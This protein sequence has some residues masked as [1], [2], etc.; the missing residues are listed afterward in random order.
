MELRHLRYFVALAE[1]LSFTRA[2]E[3]VH[4][5]QSTLSH[6]IRQLE[7]EVGQPLF[8]RI[9]KKVVTT[10][11]GELFLGFASRALK[12]VDQGIAHAQAR[13]RRPHRAGAHRRDA[14]LQHRPDP[15][16]R[17]AVPGAPSDG[18][19]AASR[20]CRPTR[21]ARSCAPASSTSASPTGRAARRDL[22]FEPLYNEEMVLVVA[23]EPSA[24]RPQAHPHGRAAP[25]AAGAAARATS[26]P[27]PCST[28]ASRRAA[29]SRWSSPRCRRSRRCSAW[30]CARRSAR[31]SAINAVPAAMSGPGDDPDREPDA[32]PH[33]GHA[34]AARGDEARRTCSRSR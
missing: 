31:S 26:P 24:R 29:P 10:E 12:E 18:A 28:S 9:G 32:D 25:A 6:Q 23:D 22:W 27:A 20:S 5:T 34:L 1:C 13:R 16:V 33:A 8:D 4:V 11:A 3:R 15:G 7:E 2:A 30:C 14:H 21:S 19:G 17:R